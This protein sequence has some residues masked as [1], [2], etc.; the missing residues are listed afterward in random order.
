MIPKSFQIG[1]HTIKVE[2]TE[3]IDPAESLGE[4]SLIKQYVKVATKSHYKNLPKT[5]IE[6]TY[7]HE[8]VHIILMMMN[9]DDLNNNEKFVDN[10]SGFLHQI[11]KTSKY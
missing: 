9:E 1:G 10:F 4:C 5:T 11:L 3:N 8:I 2:Q 7:L 6:H